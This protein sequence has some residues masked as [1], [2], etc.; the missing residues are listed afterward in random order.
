NR[1]AASELAEL[2]IP[3]AICAPHG[4]EGPGVRELLNA[5]IARVDDEDVPALIDRDAR[6]V[7]ELPIPAARDAP[8]REQGPVVRALLDAV[9]PGVGHVDV[10]ARVD[11]DALGV[12]ELSTPPL[13]KE[14]A[15]RRGTLCA[16]IPRRDQQQ[17]E[18]KT[19]PDD[20]R[21]RTPP[22]LAPLARLA[23]P[24]V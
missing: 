22:S 7:V 20:P 13:R 5:V 9:L 23:R 18:H 15:A 14:R 21:H 11:R 24:L 4:E 10:P 16:A 6:G 2:A 3:A 8:P 19:T 1:Y 12:A 17:R